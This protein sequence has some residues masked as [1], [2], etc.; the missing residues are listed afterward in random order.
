MNYNLIIIVGLPGSG[1]TFMSETFPD[2]TII[3]DYYCTYYTCQLNEVLAQY[4]KVIINDPRFCNE[5]KFTNIIEEA[6]KVLAEEQI[7][8]IFF[9]NDVQQCL[10]NLRER[11]DNKKDVICFVNKMTNKYNP[12]DLIKLIGKSD[13]VIKSVYNQI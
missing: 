6:K 7:F 1:K 12:L 3:D 5:L 9:E 13:Y 2:Y 4:P 8:Y 10:V 11:I